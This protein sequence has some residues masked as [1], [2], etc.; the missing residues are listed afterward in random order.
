[1]SYEP[2][3]KTVDNGAPGRPTVTGVDPYIEFEGD[4]GTLKILWVR[5]APWQWRGLIVTGKEVWA[6]AVGPFDITWTKA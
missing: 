3:L 1:M 4:R 5:K 2:L 6:R